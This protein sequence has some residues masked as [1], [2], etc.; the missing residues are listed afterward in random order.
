MLLLTFLHQPH[1]PVLA[2]TA[3]LMWGFSWRFTF[4]ITQTE[5]L[6]HISSLFCIK[7]FRG[8]SK[9]MGGCEGLLSC[10]F[11][12]W[13]NDFF[14]S[15]TLQRESCWR[16]TIS[17]PGPASLGVWGPESC[18]LPGPRRQTGWAQLWWYPRRTWR[19]WFP[20]RPRVYRERWESRKLWF[21]EKTKTEER[22]EII[23]KIIVTIILGIIW[24]VIILIVL[25]R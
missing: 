24:V 25:I 15:S 11:T 18:L 20:T 7:T 16:H 2:H 10:S 3:T 21:C 23:L 14:F 9:G 8:G 13:E 17:A 6:Q 5:Y 12:E 22:G 19:C 1:V 4:K